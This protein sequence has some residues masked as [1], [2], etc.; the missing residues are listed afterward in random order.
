M[1]PAANK[2]AVRRYI[3][4]RIRRELQDAQVISLDG[5]IMSPTEAQLCGL[6]AAGTP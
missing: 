6:A 2:E 5:W 3:A 4:A 1:G